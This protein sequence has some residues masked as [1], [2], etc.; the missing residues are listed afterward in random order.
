MKVKYYKIYGEQYELMPM[1]SEPTDVWAKKGKLFDDPP[2]GKVVGY[3]TMDDGSVVECHAASK[4]WIVIAAV[5]LLLLG[6]GGFV[7]YLFFGQ[8]KDVALLGDIV[9]IGSDNNVVMYNGVPAIRDD[10]LSIQF[11]NGDYPATILVEGE[12]IETHETHVEPSEFVDSVPCKF[13]TEDGLVEA[14]I[15]IKTETSTQTFPIVVEIP[16]N[17]NANDVNGGLEGYWSGE[18]IY[19]SE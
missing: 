16:A 15:T 4:L 8:P 6:V 13:T 1:S 10:K 7:A 5:L 19:G 12:G 2:R 18:Q 14:T 9:K 3:V 17:M 11:T